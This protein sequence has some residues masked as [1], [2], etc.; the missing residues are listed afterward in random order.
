MIYG[1]IFWEKNVPTA[2]RWWHQASTVREK[3]CQ[4]IKLNRYY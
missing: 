2:L 1:H 3:I 4:Y